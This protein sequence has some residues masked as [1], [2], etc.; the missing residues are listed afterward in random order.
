[1]EGPNR[2]EV[3]PSVVLH[4]A[5]LNGIYAG[6]LHRAATARWR[7]IMRPLLNSSVLFCVLL[8]VGFLACVK[9]LWVLLGDGL[10]SASKAYVW[11]VYG[12]ETRA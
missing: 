7:K 6:C 9:H 12:R 10:L 8:S 4:F 11:C 1:M 2:I 5:D 3:S